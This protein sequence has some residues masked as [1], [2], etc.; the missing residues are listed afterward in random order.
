MKREAQMQIFAAQIRKIGNGH[1]SSSMSMADRIV[2]LSRGVMQ[3]AS[4][5]LAITTI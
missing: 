2:V 4:V 3:V 1:T 5:R